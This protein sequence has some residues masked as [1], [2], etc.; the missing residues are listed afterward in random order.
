M[1][2]LVYLATISQ[3]CCPCYVIVRR[4]VHLSSSTNAPKTFRHEKH[5][6][7][8]MRHSPALAAWGQQGI[9]RLL[10]M[11]VSWW[12]LQGRSDSQPPAPGATPRAPLHHPHTAMRFTIRRR[13]KSPTCR[14]AWAD[15]VGRLLEWNHLQ[16]LQN[17][18]PASIQSAASGSCSKSCTE[19]RVGPPGARPVRPAAANSRASA[20]EILK[21]QVL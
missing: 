17:R 12:V 20:A 11:M 2:H 10:W 14:R 7:N 13:V 3:H 5:S 8:R 19:G 18:N 4:M 6:E 15:G 21:S 9:A 1:P 16:T